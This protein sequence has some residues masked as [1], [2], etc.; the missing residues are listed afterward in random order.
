MMYPSG[1]TLMTDQSNMLSSIKKLESGSETRIRH[2]I[3]YF[4]TS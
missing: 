1:D 2:I 3:L 4:G